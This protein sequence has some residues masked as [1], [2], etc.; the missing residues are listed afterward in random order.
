MDQVLPWLRENWMLVVTAQ[1]ILLVLFRGDRDGIRAVRDSIRSFQDG[2]VKVVE[3]VEEIAAQARYL[4]DLSRLSAI[5][6]NLRRIEALMEASE[7]RERERE[8]QRRARSERL[9]W[10]DDPL[11]A[12]RLQELK[13]FVEHNCGGY[14]DADIPSEVMF[15]VPF[16]N[17]EALIEKLDDLVGTTGETV[18]IPATKDPAGAVRPAMLGRCFTIDLLSPLDDDDP[19]RITCLRTSAWPGPARTNRT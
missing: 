7:R 6:S 11:L 8:R 15:S 17:N 16:D 2:I 3:V 18:M 9:K 4:P 13:H 1:F 5:E 19:D 10:Q 12:R 14:V